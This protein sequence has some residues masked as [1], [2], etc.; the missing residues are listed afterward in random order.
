M[1]KTISVVV[2]A[3]LSGQ[4]MGSDKVEDIVKRVE[5]DAPVAEVFAVFSSNE[6]VQSFFSKGSNVDF[7]PDGDYEILFFPEREVGQRGAEGMKVLAIEPDRRLSITWNAPPAWPEVRGQ[8]TVVTFSFEAVGSDHT[9]VTLNHGLWGQGS[10][11]QAVNEYFQEGWD[12]VLFRLKHRF[13]QGPVDWNKPPRP[14]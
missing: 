3:L 10:D 4:S 9:A 6:G 2:A 8:R 5:V 14:S 12:V 7:R 11:W 13:E 1:K